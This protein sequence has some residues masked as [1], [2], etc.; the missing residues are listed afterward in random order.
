MISFNKPEI[1]FSKFNSDWRESKLEDLAN[2]QK[3]KGIPKRELSDKGNSCILYG[4]LYTKYSELIYKTYNKTEL[5]LDNLVLSKKGD[6]LIPSSGETALE[7][8]MASALLLDNIAL[9]GDINVVRPNNKEIESRFLSYQ[10][11]SARRI[12]LARLAE[13]SSVVHLYNEN[14]KEVVI[15]YPEVQEQEKIA[16]F[17]ELLDKKIRLKEKKI[18]KKENTKLAYLFEMF[19]KVGKKYPEKRFEGFTEPWKKY[20]LR[21]IGYIVSGSGFPTVEQGGKEGTMF[22]KVSD[23]NLPNN[24]VTIN[25][26]N[27]YV[28]NSQIQKN[29]WTVISDT[30]AI[31][32]AKVGAALLLDRKRLVKEKFLIDNNMMAFILGDQLDTE[33]TNMLFKNIHF[34][35]YAQTGALPSM[36]DFLVEKIEVTVPT[37]EEQEKIGNFF[38]NL[39]QQIL[40]E[41][42]ELAKLK[43]IKKSYLNALII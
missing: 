40:I 1:R 15:K 6:V 41:K 37:L 29:K 43:K 5:G 39:D 27:N 11:N 16:D 8:S 25:S 2:F 20:S 19:P 13:G 32:F 7:M 12:D 35:Q 4:E 18:E 10:I 28:S 9:G 26:A 42:N 24:S 33:F 21:D 31:I 30:P 14:L 38:M 22:L 3:G 17:F 34:P 36:N 23:M